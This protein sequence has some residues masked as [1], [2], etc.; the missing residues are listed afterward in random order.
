MLS[1]HIIA[2]DYD[3]VLSDSAEHNIKASCYACKTLGFTNLPRIEDLQFLPE[4]SFT[5]LAEHLDM[6]VAMHTEFV[7]TTMNWLTHSEEQVA[8]FP[9]VI[10]FI[11]QLSSLAELVVITANHE[12]IVNPILAKNSLAGYFSQVLGEES[13]G[14]KAEKLRVIKAESKVDAEHIYMIGDATSDMV[15]AHNAGVRA[16]GVSWGFQPR[17]HLATSSPHV[18]CDTPEQLLTYLRTSIAKES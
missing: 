17:E 11:K 9:Y 18:I 14:N 12:E 2:F 5:A 4:M 3:G 10:P 1:K 7:H 13:P 8:L 15:H 6:P 16:V